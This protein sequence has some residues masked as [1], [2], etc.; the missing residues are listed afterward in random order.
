MFR[1]LLASNQ[2]AD[3]TLVCDD[4]RKISAHRIVLSACSSVF[5]EILQGH[6]EGHQVIYLRGVKHQEMESLL[7]FMYNAEASFYEDRVNEFLRV[8]KDLDIKEIAENVDIAQ[9]S[10]NENAACNGQEKDITTDIQNENE[11]LVPPTRRPNSAIT[12]GKAYP[13]DECDAEY[14]T[15]ISLCQH[16]RSVHQGAQFSCN[17]CNYKATQ[18]NNL[19]THVQSVHDGLVYPCNQCEY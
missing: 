3:V 19:K 8:A 4:L 18:K 12:T 16:R 5:R 17:Q 7:Q 10:S 1:E 14:K 13:C 9:E 11:N 6:K 2:F 15:Y